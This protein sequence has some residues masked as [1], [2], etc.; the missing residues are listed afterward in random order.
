MINI[1]FLTL[2]LQV[3]EGILLIR[4][5]DRRNREVA[6]HG[7]DA[8]GRLKEGLEMGWTD[9]EIQRPISFSTEE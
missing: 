6:F 5:K 4:K 1:S 7:N 2:N 8:F 9:I 3:M